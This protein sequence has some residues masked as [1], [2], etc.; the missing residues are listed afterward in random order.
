MFGF[1]KRRKDLIRQ[2]ASETVSQLQDKRGWETFLPPVVMDGKIY[3]M[4][5]DM[6]SGQPLIQSIR[7]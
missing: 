4:H 1:K 5:N 7:Q 3:T 2:I 6:V